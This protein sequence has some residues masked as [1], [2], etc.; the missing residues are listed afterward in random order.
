[1]VMTTG[2]AIRPR[3]A[4]GN[5]NSPACQDLATALQLMTSLRLHGSP[6]LG[7]AASL[8]AS[9][10][11]TKEAYRLRQAEKSMVEKIHLSVCL[12]RWM[13]SRRSSDVV[14]VVGPV[15]RR[16]D[17]PQRRAEHQTLGV[18]RK[19]AR[20]CTGCELSRSAGQGGWASALKRVIG[21]P[22]G[23]GNHECHDGNVGRYVEGGRPGIT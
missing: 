8:M 22:S 12:N 14:K 15:C 4:F 2:S 21:A 3:N 18:H 11:R 1:M 10:D 19:G 16:S 6:T 13:R 7:L 20:L 23:G 5:P 9:V 17:T